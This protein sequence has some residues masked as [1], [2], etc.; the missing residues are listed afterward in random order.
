RVPVEREADA[1]EK[2]RQ[3]GQTIDRSTDFTPEQP[4]RGLP[5]T[6]KRQ[7]GLFTF[8]SGSRR[9]EHKSGHKCI[10]GYDYKRDESLIYLHFDCDTTSW[11]VRNLDIGWFGD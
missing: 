9:Y 5:D 1:D 6:T 10:A 7:D 3:F 11:F 2:L 8:Y 4:G